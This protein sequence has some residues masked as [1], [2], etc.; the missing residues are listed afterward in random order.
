MS[1]ES[2]AAEE[3]EAQQD[4]ATAAEHWRAAAVAAQT[5]PAKVERL[6]RAARCLRAVGALG[7]ARQAA[8][9]ALTSATDGGQLEARGRALE[10]MAR[11][12]LAE[13]E[14]DAALHLWRTAI[15]QWKDVGEAA[16]VCRAE[17]GLA[18]AQLLGG[19]VE[20]AREIIESVRMGAPK[21]AEPLEFARAFAI[22]GAFRAMDG[23][24]VGAQLEAR[25]SKLDPRQ[26]PLEAA[27]IAV[28]FGLSLMH[29]EEWGKAMGHLHAA[30]QLYD[31][32][33]NT[34][35]VASVVVE[36]ARA[37]R[38]DGDLPAADGMLD[39]ALT[40]F[41]QL[42]DPAA[43]ARY[44][45]LL[46]RSLNMALKLRAPQLAQDRVVRLA[47]LLRERVGPDA[48]LREIAR[49]VHELVWPAPEVANRLVDTLLGAWGDHQDKRWTTAEVLALGEDL[50]SLERY[51]E[52]EDL[53]SA[54]ALWERYE[55][56]TDRDAASCLA[57]AGRVARARGDIG[58]AMGLYDQALVLG[59]EVDH[60][61][62]E[63]WIAQRRKLS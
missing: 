55:G 10:A 3:A 29:V 21:I 8:L 57:L 6:C 31:R 19:D 18:E 41:G 1:A 7:Q 60:P 53:L 48:A 59:R 56:G 45:E 14:G 50:E 44:V 16:D 11:V 13:G 62:L 40:A 61:D 63:S 39:V 28:I 4:Y 42:N 51:A 2:A 58:A 33:G 27:E 12:R 15:K 20:A 30:G 9:E 23:D 5:V 37:K 47:A 38:E 54:R 22:S 26:Y 35:A 34:R 25:F 46:R 49:I 17:V 24:E 43:R 36:L 32:L 52:A